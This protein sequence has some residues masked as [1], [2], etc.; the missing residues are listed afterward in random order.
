[1][2]KPQLV[3]VRA[4]FYVLQHGTKR[5]CIRILIHPP[6]RSETLQVADLTINNIHAKAE[7]IIYS[8]ILLSGKTFMSKRN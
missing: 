2:T 4:L 1:M 3:K 5:G 6:T 7:Y 8:N